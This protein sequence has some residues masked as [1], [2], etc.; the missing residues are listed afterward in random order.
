MA[1]PALA[2]TVGPIAEAFELFQNK[3]YV[4][5]VLKKKNVTAADGQPFG[6]KTWSPWYVE[7]CGPVL[8][9]WNLTHLPP[10]AV[11]LLKTDTAESAQLLDQIKAHHTP[12]FMNVTD[13]QVHVVGTIKKRDAVFSLNSAGANFFYFQ[14]A[15][16]SEMRTWVASLR[17]LGF[18]VCKLY[19]AY[20]LAYLATAHPGLLQAPSSPARQGYLQARFT[21]SLDW[22]PFWVVL[23]PGPSPQLQF[24]AAPNAP[25]AP[26]ATLTA[27]RHAYAIY[28][29]KL[30]LVD[31][32]TIAKVEGDFGPHEP[33]SLSLATSLQFALLMATSSQELFAWLASLY[34]TFQLYGRPQTLQC[35]QPHTATLYLDPRH[36]A[37][38]TSPVDD[39]PPVTREAFEALYRREHG[40][41]LQR[42]FTPPPAPAAAAAVRRPVDSDSES[43][44][45]AA[46]PKPIDGPDGVEGDRRQ[47]PHPAALPVRA[48]FLPAAPPAAPLDLD[49]SLQEITT[50]AATLN[51]GPPVDSGASSPEDRKPRAKP[52]ARSR[53][54]RPVASDSSDSESDDQDDRVPQHRPPPAPA[55]RAPPTASAPAVG[56]QRNSSDT[57]S[58]SQRSWGQL[59]PQAQ[60][61]LTVDGFDPPAPPMGPPVQQPS[62][63]P[64][65][66]P[67]MGFPPH[68]VAGGYFAPDPAG[69][70]A[71]FHPGY[72]PHGYPAYPPSPYAP[73]PGASYSV[74]DPAAYVPDWHE[75][76]SAAGSENGRPRLP[77]QPQQPMTLMALQDADRRQQQ[78]L[79]V[80]KAGTLV[81]LD[82]KRDPTRS[83]G[84]LV[85]AI[86]ARQQQKERRKYTDASSYL[87]NAL[88]SRQP[89]PRMH[90]TSAPA[91][92]YQSG[93]Y[94]FPSPR[95][96]SAGQLGPYTIPDGEDDDDDDVPLG[97]FA[98]Y[99]DDSDHVALAHLAPGPPR[100]R[101]SY[102][103]PRS[104]HESPD[105]YATLP[106]RGGGPQGGRVRTSVVGYGARSSTASLDDPT[107]RRTSSARALDLATNGGRPLSRLVDPEPKST[108]ARS[109]GSESSGTSSVDLDALPEDLVEHFGHFMEKHI[110]IKPYSVVH[111]TT[112]YNAY[113]AYC[114]RAK[115]S[116]EDTATRRQ[117]V[118]L[119]LD[120]DFSKRRPKGQADGGEQ[121]CDIVLLD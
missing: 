37:V 75:T 7:L 97:G 65:H 34:D 17:L 81:Q 20:T 28:P 71:S 87:R 114:Y 36:P 31:M 80:Q 104:P 89:G 79:L 9:F 12:N 105:A 11:E 61:A 25:G 16:P 55:A 120:N 19:E 50:R 98:R 43:E 26:L 56:P 78:Q 22:Q 8:V 100:Q 70:R 21:G 92:A 84:G 41:P 83:G 121:W 74:Y 93:D 44:G 27:A 52:A 39:T 24:F 14:A 40:P 69:P 33:D 35:P 63:P 32:A 60:A 15:S 103:V 45:D 10:D 66:Q 82:S 51:V 38:Q 18:E 4:R 42:T 108:R 107:F 59:P 57:S 6:A 3:L 86:A 85:G 67:M 2:A 62:L 106:R 109:R 29:E 96:H 68:P 48:S 47:A 73:Y 118:A 91:A 54:V 49:R 88:T 119:M 111:P 90:A 110:E 113:A 101:S 64:P 116:P 76:A 30:D 72:P 99:D 115:V 23:Q 53:A 5:G 1:S 95:L 112:L 77:P 13:C 117:L 46:P 94:G 102:Y 58:S